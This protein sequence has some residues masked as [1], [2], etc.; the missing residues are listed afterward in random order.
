MDPKEIGVNTSNCVDWTKDR[1]Y[2]RKL[3]ECDTELPDFI[4]YVVG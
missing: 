4:G 2:W 1:D 3:C